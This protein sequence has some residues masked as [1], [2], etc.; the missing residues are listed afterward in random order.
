MFKKFWNIIRSSSFAIVFSIF[1][2]ILS[3]YITFYYEK[4]RVISVTQ[5]AITKVFD[6]YQPV[7]GLDVFYAGESLRSANKVLWVINYTIKNTGDTGLKIDDYDPREPLGIQLAGGKVVETP[8]YSTNKDYLTKNLKVNFDK[9]KI[10]ISPI[11][12]EPADQ[13]NFSILVLGSN[14]QQPK[15]KPTGVF[16]GFKPITLSNIEVKSKSIVSQLFDADSVFIYPLRFFCY[17]FAFILILLS[18]TVPISFFGYIRSKVDFYRRSKAME[19]YKTKEDLSKEDRYLLNNYIANGVNYL[20]GIAQVIKHLENR[21]NINE[22][23]KSVED[24]EFKSAV[25]EK[26]T[27]QNHTQYIGDL[28]IKG[29]LH[30]DG[31]EVLINENLTKALREF[32]NNL[33]IDFFLDDSSNEDPFS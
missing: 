33:N 31:D 28:L 27:R 16:A 23:L 24:E 19:S 14:Q 6:I 10:T 26:F 9:D 12:F 22:K 25:L 17:F 20:K 29:I 2:F 4:S 13:I 7:G 1:T 32:G 18:L 21:V 30:K 8:K 3:L 15:I 5:N 11:I